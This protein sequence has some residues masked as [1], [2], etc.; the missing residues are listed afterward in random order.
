[1]GR[2]RVYADNKEQKQR[3]ELQDR[4]VSFLPVGERYD[5]GDD[6]IVNIL[7]DLNLG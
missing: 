5:V 4:G 2:E 6:D 1:M 7:D 3:W